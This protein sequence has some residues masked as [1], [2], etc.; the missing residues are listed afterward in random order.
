MVLVE[1]KFFENMSADNWHYKRDGTIK[2][3]WCV[4]VSLPMM[5][6]E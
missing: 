4:M 2:K 5:G 1:K 3:G 6:L